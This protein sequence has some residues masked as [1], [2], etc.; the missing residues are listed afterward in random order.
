VSPVGQGPLS[1]LLHGHRTRLIGLA[2]MA[3][4]G[5]LAESVVLVVIVEA[6]VALSAHTLGSFQ[7]G[8]VQLV[9]VSVTTLLVVALV[10]TVLRLGAA[11]GVAWVG[12]RLTADVQKEMRVAMFDAYIDADWASQS[13]EREGGLQQMIG[14]EIDRSAGAVLM[15][16]TG[17]A[18]ACS[19]LVLTGAALMVNPPGAIGLI[20]AVGGLFVLLRPLS[21]RIRRHA[22]ARSTEELG[23]AESLNELVRTS[24]E[25]RVHG[26]SDEE[27]RRL[28]LETTRVSDWVARIQFSSLSVSN[29]YQGAALGLV[30]TALF[31]VN[32][33]G[34]ANVAGAGAIVLILLRAFA[35]SQQVQQAHQQV[36]ERSASVVSVD[37]RLASYRA[38]AA[39]PGS[40]PLASVEA[41]EFRNVSYWYRPG[42][43]AISDVSF[44]VAR[45]EVIGVVGP[46]GAG[47][48][49]LV[50]LLLR[51]RAPGQGSYLVNGRDA[52]DYTNRDWARNV[53]FLPQQPKLIAGTVAENI[54]FF[55]DVTFDQI[56]SAARMANLNADIMAWPQGYATVVGQRAD[57]LSGGQ[58]QRL[59]LARALVTAPAMLVLDE[60]TSALDAIS[61]HAV[62]EALGAVRGQTT[63]FIV[64]HR[65]STL[66]ICDRI[67]VLN[68]GRLEA[69]DTRECLANEGGFYQEALR[70]S[71]LA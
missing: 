18:A 54:R 29:L 45:G 66:S 57:A 33:L 31:V 1:R 51:L 9:R 30:V 6:A 13:R 16:A 43:A 62:Q 46:S 23:V 19:L 17:L 53:S 58:A 24:E 12:A 71:G 61:E 35:Y 28:A 50:Q 5:G 63:I 15:L 55:R 65:L 37:E 27:K 38:S 7:A 70:L 32:G 44:S 60:P 64:A 26:V 3:L 8:P 41:L 48:S 67:L 11:L 34:A 47:K 36:G 56:E 14:L 39:Q 21:S 4:I 2:V 59:C 69:I 10:A 40:L 49:T 42:R 25:I 20:A 52:V 68:D 22:S